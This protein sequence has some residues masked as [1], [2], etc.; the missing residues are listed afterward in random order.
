MDMSS[1]E[2]NEGCNQGA[3]TRN[4]RNKCDEFSFTT[5]ICL[6]SGV[7]VSTYNTDRLVITTKHPTFVQCKLAVGRNFFAIFANQG[8]VD[9]EIAINRF[10]CCRKC[11]DFIERS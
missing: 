5:C 11:P 10:T 2:D 3:S 4:D 7:R 1:R 9:V 6:W 8:L